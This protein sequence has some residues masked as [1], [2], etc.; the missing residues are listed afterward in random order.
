MISLRAFIA[1]FLFAFATPA[2]SAGFDC[3]KAFSEVEILICNSTELNHMD[4]ELNVLYQSAKLHAEK[5]ALLKLLR[6]WLVKRNTCQD[7]TCLLRA[8]KRFLPIF[9]SK[10]GLSAVES[11]RITMPIKAEEESEAPN[12]VQ[13]ST[14]ESDIRSGV[15]N[16]Q[17]VTWSA[18]S[19][20]VAIF[21]YISSLNIWLPAIS[22]LL[23]FV[24]AQVLSLKTKCIIIWGWWDLL[25]LII[26]A[27]VVFS[28][29][30]N[31]IDAKPFLEI[32]KNT[33][34]IIFYSSVAL[35]I[36]FSFI[37]NNFN[38]IFSLASIAMKVVA[39]VIIP[40]IIFIFLLALASGKKDG[41]FK[42]GT[43]GN[44]KTMLL[45]FVGALGFFLVG[46]LVKTETY[47]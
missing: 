39:I 29:F 42:D 38:I 16:S 1:V 32:H 45:A 34:S 23:I 8:Y 44:A 19:L 6:E 37:S 13:Q 9:E 22:I 3:S 7:Q 31:S 4:D 20:L 41:R 10:V 18:D 43:K 25:L 26:P 21:K 28:S 40:A 12:A 47:E 36:S 17:K 14:N 15:A 27:S 11:T 2:F 5:T 46:N 35:T 30:L 24:V 33:I